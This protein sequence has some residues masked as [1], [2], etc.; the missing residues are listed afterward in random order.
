MTSSIEG[1]DS[2]CIGVCAM[3]DAGFCEGCFRTLEE[4]TQWWN[5]EDVRRQAIQ[6][7]LDERRKNLIKFD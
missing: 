2:P 3:N 4:I 1:I 7:R 6:Q 5:M